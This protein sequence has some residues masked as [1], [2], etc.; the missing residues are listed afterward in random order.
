MGRAE[1]GRQGV[2]ANPSPDVPRHTGVCRVSCRTP[3][4]RDSSTPRRQGAFG[5]LRQPLWR[6]PVHRAR[7]A[8]RGD[9]LAVVG[10]HG[11]RHRGQP[12]LQFLLCD[13]VA[14]LRHGRQLA[15]QHRRAGDGVLGEPVQGAGQQALAQGGRQMGQEHLAAGGGVQRG[16]PAEPVLRR[17][18]GGA[19][20]LHDVDRR[21]VVQ[22][23]DVR[24]L[25]QFVGEFAADGYALLRDVQPHRRRPREAQHARPQVVL[26]ALLLL[27][28]QAAVLQDA[29]QPERGG[30]VHVQFVGDLGDARLAEAG[31]DLQHAHGTVH[32]LHAAG[33]ASA[34]LLVLH[35]ILILVGLIPCAGHG[36]TP[37]TRRT[38][39]G[40]VC[41]KPLTP[42]TPARIL[43]RIALS[44]AP[45]ETS[46]YRSV[47][48]AEGYAPTPSRRGPY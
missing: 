27:G 21:V 42:R 47:R 12:D 29:E 35:V 46:C 17:H 34:G 1:S 15:A 28:H 4:R 38:L 48:I 11:R 22:H 25:A 2:R 45:C 19:A 36:S 20:G 37:T 8:D 3:M 32:R 26:A 6:Q 18:R 24:R 14:L 13:G 9:H 31:E 7:D 41:G 5:Q 39:S 40:R 23:R 33:R 10:A 30:L 43:L 16:A 44:S